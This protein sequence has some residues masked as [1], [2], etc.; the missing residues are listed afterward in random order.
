MGRRK[1]VA[2]TVASLSLALLAFGGYAAWF[3]LA[4]GD[5][6][7]I[8]GDDPRILVRQGR[9]SG[10]TALLSGTLRYD[11]ATRCLV[12]ETAGGERRGA[13]WPAG[14]RPVNGGGARGVVIGAF[15]GRFGGLTVLEGD[16]VEGGGGGELTS[17][18]AERSG[19]APGD[20]L[21]F[22]GG[23]RVVGESAG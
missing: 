3:H 6:V 18:T 19:C 10:M 8:V 20:V 12:I 14:T 22:T 1:L 11:D 5:G 17:G 15:I 4:T 9:Y 23:V 21:I 13:V 2:W 16:Q 7:D